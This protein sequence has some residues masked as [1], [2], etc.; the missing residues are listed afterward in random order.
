MKGFNLTFFLLSVLASTLVF[1]GQYEVWLPKDTDVTKRQK[2]KIKTLSAEDFLVVD[3][4][5]TGPNQ[6]AVRIEF[7]EIDMDIIAKF[8]KEEPTNYQK[9]LDTKFNDGEILK[10]DIIVELE[11][12]EDLKIILRSYKSDLWSF[13][14]NKK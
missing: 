3:G 6:R 12:R 13:K 10:D 2:V 1:A 5:E 4:V 7:D 11:K 8:I 9:L 14:N